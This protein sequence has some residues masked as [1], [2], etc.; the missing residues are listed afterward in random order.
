[1][2]RRTI[3]ERPE[4]FAALDLGLGVSFGLAFAFGALPISKATRARAMTAVGNR[5]FS[6]IMKF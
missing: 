5:Y 4:I 2:T 6:F 3:A 1:M